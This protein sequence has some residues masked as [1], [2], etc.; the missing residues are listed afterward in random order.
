[1]SGGGLAGRPSVVYR[2]PL[3]LEFDAR[4]RG[5]RPAAPYRPAGSRPDTAGLCTTCRS[6]ARFQRTLRA[7]WWLPLMICSFVPPCELLER[8]F[9]GREDA[10][11]VSK[12][13]EVK[14]CPPV[15]KNGSLLS[16]MFFAPR[17]STASTLAS[18]QRRY[19]SRTSAKR[20]LRW[21]RA[22]V[23]AG[24]VLVGF[25]CVRVRWTRPVFRFAFG[26]MQ[27]LGR[28]CRSAR[29]RSRCGVCPASP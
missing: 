28:L 13:V 12:Y 18:P 21:R 23:G 26:R 16:G 2:F 9:D 22:F 20:R 27:P 29:S 10:V 4:S 8:R 1:M 14:L 19:S 15:L 11:K 3:A 25:P 17:P 6:L 24:L 7:S 5:V